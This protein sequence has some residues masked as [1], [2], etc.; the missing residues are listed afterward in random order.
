MPEDTTEQDV[1]AKEEAPQ[2]KAET[3]TLRVKDQVGFS[4]SLDP[5]LNQRAVTPTK[6]SYCPRQF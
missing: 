4:F 5:E 6:S 2:P 1:D 3:I